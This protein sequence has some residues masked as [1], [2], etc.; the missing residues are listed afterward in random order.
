[1][2]NLWDILDP[3]PNTGGLWTHG[4]LCSWP[5]VSRLFSGLCP[6][7]QVLWALWGLGPRMWTFCNLGIY[8]QS[9]KSVC[10]FGG[11]F[12]VSWWELWAIWDMF[13]GVKSLS[14]WTISVKSMMSL[15][16]VLFLRGGVCL[17][18]CVTVWYHCLSMNWGSRV[19]VFWAV[20]GFMSCP[21]NC[22]GELTLKGMRS[23]RYLPPVPL[24]E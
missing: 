15:T 3:G 12:C 17:A 22:F 2:W 4:H 20:W 8:V 5:N 7:V 6:R 10:F 11:R 18:I 19:W 13:P 16:S 9:M 23:L 1:M 21:L 14:L 24:S